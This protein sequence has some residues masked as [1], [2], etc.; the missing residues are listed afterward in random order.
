MNILYKGNITVLFFRDPANL[1]RFITCI[2][3]SRLYLVKLFRGHSQ[4]NS[5]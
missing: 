3:Q 5:A 4:L 1:I 2:F